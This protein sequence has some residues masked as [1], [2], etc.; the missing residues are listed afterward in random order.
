VL[1]VANVAGSTFHIYDTAGL[2][3]GEKGR[4]P[5]TEAIVQLYSLL[6]SLDTGVNLLVF[7]MRGPRLKSV[8][9]HNWRFFHDIVCQHKVPIVLAITGL[10]HEVVMDDWW[11]DNKSAFQEQGLLP[12]GV[13]CI[14]AIKG[15]N[16]AFEAEYE[17]SRVK[18][19]RVLTECAFRR[20]WKAKPVE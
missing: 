8:A 15:K 20:P 5:S 14:T 7:C 6:Q 16:N 10:E 4:V 3:E 11:Q 1:L 12:N 18:M 17:E 19:H 9:H 2:N 13:A